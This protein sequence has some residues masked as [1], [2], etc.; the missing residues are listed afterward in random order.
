MIRVWYDGDGLSYTF[1][2]WHPLSWILIPI[3]VILTISIEGSRN[4]F[5]YKEDLGIGLSKYWKEHKNERVFVTFK[6][7]FL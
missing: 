5:K 7:T 4:T 2:Y 6:D 1:N 3:L